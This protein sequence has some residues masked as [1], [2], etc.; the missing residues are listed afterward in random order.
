LMLANR[1]RRA[2]ENEEFILHYQPKVGGASRRV[3]GV[4]A[5]LRWND[6]ETGSIVMPS[7]IIPLLEETGLIL[8]VGAWAVRRALADAAGWRAAGV[9]PPRIAVNVSTV[10]L[11]Q[12]GFVGEIADAL[13]GCPEEAK[14]LDLEITESM[15]MNDLEMNIERLAT[16][17]EMGLNISID[18]FGTG[19]SSLGYLARLPVNSLKIDQ[20]FVMTM[21]TRPESMNIVS[22]IISLAHSLDLKVIAEGVETEEQAKFLALLKCDELQ[23]FLISRPI[24]PDDLHRFLLH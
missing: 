7:R 24:P 21:T 3:T 12:Q 9:V 5:L 17:R 6:P 15:M 23:G 20:S 13:Q 11:Q 10:Q 19:Y 16:M 14:G 18:D 1:L 8:Q 2:L 4:E 22:T